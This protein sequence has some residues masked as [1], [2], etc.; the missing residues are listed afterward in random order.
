MG[1]LGRALLLSLAMHILFFRM[2]VPDHSVRLPE[3]RGSGQV[4]VSIVRLA[5]M[6]AA[7]S[8]REPE[9]TPAPV[10]RE[11]Q[12]K[13]ESAAGGRAPEPAATPQVRPEWTKKVIRPEPESDGGPASEDD[14]RP[15]TGD[16]PVVPRPAAGEKTDAPA[17]A[18]REAVR[19]AA[20]LT[21]ENS[22]PDYPLLARKRGWEGTV[23]L[24][25]RVLAD[26]RIQG[27]EVQSSS[28]YG[29]LDDAAL[30][31]VRQWRFQPGTRGGQAVAM[32]VLVPV[33]FVLRNDEG[34]Q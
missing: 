31:A 25:V 1:R 27:V 20:P 15:E 22:P 12:K 30:Q 21:A 3:V 7:V 4:T 34:S 32:Q 19:Q 9:E 2:A 33:H 23:V 5:P 8:E 17:P 10:R 18:A 13:E 11:E 16:G 29:L 6:P 14:R 28:S 26:G 24:A